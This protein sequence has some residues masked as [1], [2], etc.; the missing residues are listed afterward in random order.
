MNPYCLHL[1]TGTPQ[2]DKHNPQ[3]STQQLPFEVFASESNGNLEL[4]QNNVELP[5]G[6][7]FLKCYVQFREE[8][9]FKFYGHVIAITPHAEVFNRK[10]L[11][12]MFKILRPDNQVHEIKVMISMQHGVP[13]LK[14]LFYDMHRLKSRTAYRAAEEWYATWKVLRVDHRRQEHNDVKKPDQK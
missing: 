11:M 10:S 13:S 3:I 2:N 8:H 9:D 1:Q 7:S 5:S 6:P 12:Y 4:V 14:Q